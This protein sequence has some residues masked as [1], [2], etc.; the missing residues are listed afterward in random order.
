MLGLVTSS[1]YRV[2]HFSWHQDVV[3]R[4]GRAALFSTIVCER[5]LTERL[6][7]CHMLRECFGHSYNITKRYG[8]RPRLVLLLRQFCKHEAYDCSPH[9]PVCVINTPSTFHNQQVR[10]LS[11]NKFGCS[12]LWSRVLRQH[13]LSCIT[14]GVVSATMG[15]G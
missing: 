2:S 5:P 3:H 12:C 9:Y 13:C 6:Y 1:S 10:C 14:R 4:T 11:V 7:A 15:I 8:R